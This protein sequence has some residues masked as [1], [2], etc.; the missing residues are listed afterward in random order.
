M[1]NDSSQHG[2]DTLSALICA[3]VVT[4]PSCMYMTEP[5]GIMLRVKPI[6]AASS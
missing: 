2:Q 3:E 1:R 4:N 6:D 5:A